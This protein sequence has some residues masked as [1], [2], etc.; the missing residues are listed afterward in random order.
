MELTCNAFWGSTASKNCHESMVSSLSFSFPF[1]IFF[2]YQGLSK[3]TTF[4]GRF[5][6][7]MVK[8]WIWNWKSRNN[9][10]KH[11]KILFENNDLFRSAIFL[12][13]RCVPFSFY[14]FFISLGWFFFL[15]R[16]KLLLNEEQK[17]LAIAHLSKIWSHMKSLSACTEGDSVLSTSAQKQFKRR[18]WRWS[19]WVYGS[20]G[21]NAKAEREWEKAI[22]SRTVGRNSFK[23]SLRI[24][25]QR[26]KDWQKI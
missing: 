15:F 20:G 3:R 17:G 21:V 7:S 5:L 9:I 26:R 22:V 13:P 11:F 12:D 23:R 4:N 18:S 16:Y 2:W 14:L 8:M 24:I 10:L 1:F 19:R 6:F 25:L